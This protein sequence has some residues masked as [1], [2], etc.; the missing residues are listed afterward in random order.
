[1]NKKKWLTLA[2][3]AALSMNGGMALAEEVPVHEGGTDVYTADDTIVTATRTAKKDV[4]VPASTVVL[5]SEKIKES[6]ANN[7]AEAL[8]KVN[9]FTYKSFGARGASMGTMNNELIIRGNGNGTLVLINGNPVSWRGKYNLEMIP[10]DNIER[11]EIVK[12]GGSVLYGSEAMAG[13]VNIILK[14]EPANHISMGVGNFGQQNYNISAGDDALSMHYSFDRWGEQQGASYTEVA[15]KAFNGATRTDIHD[16]EKS[17]WGFNFKISPKLELVYENFQNTADFRRYVDRVDATSKGI[18]TGEQFNGRKYKTNQHMTQLNYK[19]ELWKGS[20][21]WNTGTVESNG[22]TYIGTTG[23]AKAPSNWYGTKERN[24]TYGLDAQRTWQLSGK[25]AAIA[26]VDF[27]REIYQKLAAYSTK[28][29]DTQNR[30]RNNWGVF[31][32]WEQKFDDKNTG[33]FGVRETWT[34]GAAENYNNLS[35]SLQLLHKMN[36]N[37]NIYASVNRSFIMPTFAQM[38]GSSALAIPAPDLKPQT[39]MNYEVGWKQTHNAH[40]W[41]LAIFHTDVKDNISASWDKKKESYQ[42]TNEDFRNTG[43]E[44]SCDIAAKNGWS[45]QYGATWQNPQAKSQAKGDYWDRIMG[46]LQLTGGITYKKDKLTSSLTGSYLCSRVQSP[47]KEQS[48]A[49]KPYFLTSW[50]TAYAPDDNTELALTIDNL[51]DRDDMPS[52]SS[53]SYHAAPINY[54]LSFSYKF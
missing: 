6:G 37:N 23:Y 47:S 14:K 15:S 4:D 21:Y 5:T 20:L 49:A 19:D 1:M 32:Q 35:A 33:I 31:G 53:S 51:L 11:I 29:D 44:L 3:M 7:A 16:N 9:G 36:K 2:V 12:G 41:R 18:S 8:S 43:I 17:N 30:Q 26:G 48:F 39:G 46:K 45:Y 42:Y 28:A 10:S 22:P 38:F 52:H 24:T 34:S 13:V 40:N 27:Q 50:R 54:M 25:S